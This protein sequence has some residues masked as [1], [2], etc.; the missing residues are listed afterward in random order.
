MGNNFPI[1]EEIAYEKIQ[2][3]MF[4]MMAEDPE[5][6]HALTA[7]LNEL[8]DVPKRTMTLILDLMAATPFEVRVAKHVRRNDPKTFERDHEIVSNVRFLGDYGGIAVELEPSA[9]FTEARTISITMIEMPRR[10]PLRKRVN[11]Y[12][13]K[14]IKNLRKQSAE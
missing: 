5:R 14:R 7:R 2:D 9:T 13:K 10:H 6:F 12:R 3:L 4:D 11:E 1:N 8:A